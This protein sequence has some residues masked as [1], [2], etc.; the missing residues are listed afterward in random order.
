MTSGSALHGASDAADGSEAPDAPGLLATS[1]RQP[2]GA[3]VLLSLLVLGLGALA[4]TSDEISD[5]GSSLAFPA[6][7]LL[8]LAYALLEVLLVRSSQRELWL[9][10]PAVQSALFLHFLPTASALL[11]PLL[12]EELTT[13]AFDP[14]ADQWAIRY[15]WLNLIGAVALWTGYWSGAANVVARALARSSTLERWIRPQLALRLGVALF[16]V[17]I[18][19]GI[20]LL[21]IRLGLYGYSASPEKRELAEAYSQYLAMAGELGKVTLVAVSMATFLG[22]LS[23][24]PMLV[25]LLMETGFGILSGFK[26]AVILPTII[27]GMCAYAVR[28]RLPLLFLPTII[29]GVFSA[30]AII[31]PFRAARYK[32]TEFDGTSVFSIVGTF[33]ASRDSVYESDADGPMA[34]TTASFVERATDV[35][36]A[37]NGIEFAERWDVLPEGSPNFLEDIF[38]SPLYSVIPRALW[39]GKPVN[40]VGLWYTQ[41]V[42]G[43]GT[44][45]STAMYPV[46]YLNFAGGVVAVVLG[47]LVVGVLQSALF[48][49]IA[50]HG[51]A[52]VF[53]V[54]CLVGSLGHVDS[55]YYSFFISLIRNVPFLF[56]LQWALFRDQAPSLE[57]A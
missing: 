26:T 2:I 44:T 37:A 22:K 10:N 55:V 51:G 49:G 25:L 43:E 57:R 28:G 7:C 50:T 46:T 42:M 20:R 54:A 31:Q 16:L 45:S 34:A 48:R 19:S 33:A 14:S 11:L 27:V 30:Y 1:S 38:L 36:S 17:L 3:H 15:E 13:G 9:L 40:D 39:E 47:F 52:A 29:I 53:I 32:E 41:V 24:W 56:A 23:K 4:K 8:I 18:S 6:L 21:A 12:P 5:T 35:T